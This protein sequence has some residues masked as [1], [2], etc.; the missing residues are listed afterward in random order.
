MI[1][2]DGEKILKY[3]NLI[4]IIFCRFFCACI[5]HMALMPEFRLGLEMMKYALNH[6]YKFEEGRNI[7]FLVGF[8]K[9]SIIIIVELICILVCCISIAPM[10]IVY[11]FISLAII[12]DFDDYI[13]ESFTDCL[14][15]L[16]EEND[17]DQDQEQLLI[18][19][20]TTSSMCAPSELSD[21][22]DKKTGEL[23]PLRI[24]F[25]SRTPGQKVGYMLY[26]TMKCFFVSFYFYFMPFLVF[27]ILFW[28]PMAFY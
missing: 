8:I 5:L 20:H 10:A 16:I 15:T 2:T 18:I 24:S 11:N 25:A 23:R 22:V 17:E 19:S 1:I 21:E 6:A 13:F 7:A 9:A 26:K 4:S 14:K 12:A 28:V 27:V 3:E